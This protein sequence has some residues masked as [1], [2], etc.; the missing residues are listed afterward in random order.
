MPEYLL[1]AAAADRLRGQAADFVVLDNPAGH[2]PPQDILPL[3]PCYSATEALPPA[4]LVDMDGTTT[5]TEDLCLHALEHMV[6]RFT[7][8][9]VIAAWP[10]LDPDRDYPHIIGTSA[11]SNVEYLAGL[12]AHAFQ[13][14]LAARAVV[15]AVAWTRTSCT[16]PGRKQEI[17]HDLRAME[18]AFLLEDPAFHASCNAPDAP[19]A[20]PLCDAVAQRLARGNRQDWVRAGSM[21]YYHVIHD[22]MQRIGAGQ[23]ASVAQELYGPKHDRAIVPFAGIAALFALVRGYLGE[24]AALLHPGLLADLPAA[25]RPHARDAA[26][27]DRLAARFQTEPAKVGLV[28]SSSAPEADIILNEVFLGLRESVLD[29]PVSEACRE[30]LLSAFES[31]RGF[32][33]VYVTA[34]DCHEMRLKP[35]RDLYAVA[36]HQLN[37]GPEQRRNILG[38]EDT[39]AGILAQRAAGIGLPIA[40]PFHGTRNHPFQAAA[41]VCQGGLPEALLLHGLY[42][43]DSEA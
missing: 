38:F 34:S 14:L 27:L 11:T 35:H 21:V 36:L 19:P 16:I 15:Q 39:E 30:Q 13:P 1:P 31:P 7:G 37:M 8:W 32:Y 29:W 3:G 12:H 25:L 28:T 4:I 26:A 17:S 40:V 23:T 24:E 9:A 43:A 6:R 42:I 22:L 2:F 41:H 5:S 20:Q 18:L 33:D 10:G